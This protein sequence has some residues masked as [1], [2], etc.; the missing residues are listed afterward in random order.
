MPLPK[1]DCGF[2]KAHNGRW[3][4]AVVALIVMTFVAVCAFALGLLFLG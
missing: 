2:C 1:C 4:A 3:K